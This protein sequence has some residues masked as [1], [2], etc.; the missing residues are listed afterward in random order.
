MH[1]WKQPKLC[2]LIGISS[3]NL[4]SIE[5]PKHPYHRSIIY[6]MNGT[7]QNWGCKSAGDHITCLQYGVLQSDG[8][9]DVKLIDHYVRK[10]LNQTVNRY[11]YSCGVHML[12][13]MK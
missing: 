13:L 4:A 8:R 3:N 12:K 5:L 2:E 1:L 7:S 11:V 9:I 10:H 6:N